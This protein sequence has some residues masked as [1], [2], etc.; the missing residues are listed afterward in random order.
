[1]EELQEAFQEVAATAKP[2]VEIIGAKLPRQFCKFVSP[3]HYELLQVCEP[4]GTQSV[5]EVAKE[6]EIRP[7]R[8]WDWLR[9]A[10]RR[11]ELK[12]VE[13]VPRRACYMT[14]LGREV[15]EKSG[16]LPLAEEYLKGL[17]RLIPNLGLPEKLRIWTHAKCSL[18]L[19]HV[20]RDRGGSYALH[21]APAMYRQACAGFLELADTVTGEWGD[22]SVTCGWIVAVQNLIM[23]ER[24]KADYEPDDGMRFCKA[25]LARSEQ[26]MDELD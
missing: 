1:M 26:L 13:L 14:E 23:L 8:L 7:E 17:E 11:L 25:A 4:F 16:R 22:P 19:G 20:Y 9:N 12:L 10:R 18:E 5:R 15:R 24:A 3:K 21:Q 2:L 6:M